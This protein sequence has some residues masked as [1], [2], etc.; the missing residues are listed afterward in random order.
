MLIYYGIDISKNWLDFAVLKK[1]A[2]ISNC[3]CFRIDNTTSDLKKLKASLAKKG[4]AFGKRSLAVF[5]HTGP[6]KNNLLNFLITERS[7]IC[8]EVALRI[9]RSLGI[10]RGKNDVIDAKRILKYAIRHEDTLR[11]WKHP[12]KSLLQLKTLLSTRDRLLKL[13]TAGY[14]PLNEIARF[15]TKVFH[16]ELTRICN[17]MLSGTKKSIQLVN[18]EIQRIAQQD[19]LIKHEVE[20]LCSVPGIGLMIAL[21]LICYTHEFTLCQTKEQL[22]SYVGVAPFEHSSGSSVR[23]KMRVSKMANKKLKSMLHIAACS[24]IRKTGYFKAY[25]DRKVSE[26]KHKMLVL[27]NIRNKIVRYAFL[28][29]ERDAPFVRNNKKWKPLRWQ[30]IDK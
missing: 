29:I 7:N 6:Y 30:P 27:N 2:P 26:G 20:L 5:E 28:V 25:Y 8:V 13:N 24:S 12:R 3:K 4:Y 10:Q 18:H 21:Y 19:P 23:G 14:V 15:S 1:G 22:A 9:K 11:L 17:P 16:K